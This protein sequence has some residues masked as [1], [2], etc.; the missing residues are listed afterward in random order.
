MINEILLMRHF[1]TQ[2]THCTSCTG[3]SICDHKD[4]VIFLHIKFLL[5]GSF[6]CIGKRL[7]DRTGQRAVFHF[8]ISKRLHLESCF[9]KFLQLVQCLAAVLIGN[10]CKMQGI[11]LSSRFHHG[12]EYLKFSLFK[13]RGNI[14][15]LIAEPEIRLVGSIPLHALLPGQTGKVFR[16]FNL[17][18]FPEDAAHQLFNDRKDIIFLYEAHLDINLGKLRLTVGTQ[19]FIPETSGNLEV[20]FHSCNHQQLL[21]DLRRLRQRPETAVVDS[22]RNQIVTGTFRCRS[23]QDR[24]GNLN[25]SLFIQHAA[26]NHLNLMPQD[27]ILLK[28]LSSEVEVPVLET[29][30]LTGIRI[31]CDRDRRSLRRIDDRYFRSDDFHL[32]GRQLRVRILTGSDGTGNLKDVFTADI[33]YGFRHRLVKYDLTDTGAVPQINKYE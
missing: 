3:R 18:Q 4:N 31:V 24:S 28:R 6:F 27:Q 25:K 29:D 30:I 5:D 26:G 15:D 23:C 12:T 10:S 17:F 33:L 16:Q 21:V 1:H 11:D 8:Q 32:T 9:Q 7:G 2:R 20:P 19:I 13:Q 14:V 22:G